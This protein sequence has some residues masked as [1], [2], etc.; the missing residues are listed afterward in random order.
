MAQ[1]GTNYTMKVLFCFG[2]TF[3][4]AGHV[5]I[6]GGSG[7]LSFAFNLF[8]VQ[9]FHVAVFPFVAGYFYKARYEQDPKLFFKK[10][11]LRLIVPL[12]GLSWVYGAF[13]AAVHALG[14]TTGAAPTP[15]NL[16]LDPILGAH[17]FMW[18]CPLWFVAPFFLA[19]VIDFCLRLLLK[20]GESRRK[21]M[22]LIVLYA[23][24]GMASAKAVLVVLGPNG[25]A[26]DAS[27]AW[28]L[29]ARTGYFL[30]CF[31]L[32]RLYRVFLEP[33]AKRVP[34][35]LW[36]GSCVCLQLAISYACGGNTTFTV[37]HSSYYTGCV[38]PYLTTAT[39]IAFWLRVSELLAPALKHSKSMNLVANSTYSIMAHQFFAFWLVKCLFAALAAAGAASGF[40]FGAFYNDL[41]Y[42][43]APS[44]LG[45]QIRAFGVVYIAVGILVP[46]GIHWCWERAKS[47]FAS[48][49]HAV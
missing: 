17:A 3:I 42:Y 38:V 41:W 49:L 40:D 21:E 22:A 46:C 16:L 44:A 35:A 32:G 47:R 5:I 26:E 39:G 4:V 12:Y 29:L 36:L 23:V 7:G 34:N 14:F 2:I 27:S 25:F 20:V 43:W 1:E 6:D 30:P 48:A 8:P 28:V 33:Y 19:Q 31:G 45:S 10:K 24:A 18:D 15:Y 9:G 13:T 37:S 11:F